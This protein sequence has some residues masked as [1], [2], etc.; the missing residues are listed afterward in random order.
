MKKMTLTLLVLAALILLLGSA[1]LQSTATSQHDGLELDVSQLK[2]NPQEKPFLENLKIIQEV[3]KLERENDK[4]ERFFEKSIKVATLL[5]AIAGLIGAFITAYKYFSDTEI[6]R[7]AESERRE[8]EFK[9][10]GVDKKREFEEKT[11]AILGDLCSESL[12][13]Q[14]S[15]IASLLG[16]IKP[17]NSE[18]LDTIL[19]VLTINLKNELGRKFVILDCLTRALEKT[20][21]LMLDDFAIRQELKDIDLTRTTLI[22]PNLENLLFRGIKVDV[23]FS[24][25]IQANLENADLHRLRGIRVILNKAKLSSTTLQ[26]ARLNKAECQNASFKNSNLVSATLKSANLRYSDFEGAR[27]Q[28]AHLEGADIRDANF[29]NADLNDTYLYNVIL[30]DVVKQ[31]IITAKNWKKAHFNDDVKQELERLQTPPVV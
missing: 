30:N 12:S 6:Q 3:R 22:R 21:K 8:K 25:L 27:L 14:A 10:E 9:Q 4:S 29:E 24:S 16:F 19:P 18:Y 23:A 15:A 20:L 7:K 5:T 2:G 31:S 13:L 26:E 17:I 28:S 11:A 1:T